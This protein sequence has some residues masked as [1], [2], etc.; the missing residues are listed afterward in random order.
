MFLFFTVHDCKARCRGSYPQK[1][2]YKFQKFVPLAPHGDLGIKRV[3]SDGKGE[4]W[5]RMPGL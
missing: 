4:H 5:P 3:K 1:D 2:R